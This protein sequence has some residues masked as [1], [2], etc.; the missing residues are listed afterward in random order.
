MKPQVGGKPTP[1][2][3]LVILDRRRRVADAYIRGIP[4]YQIARLESVHESQISRD[5][6]AIR[7]EWLASAVRD[8]DARKAEELAKLDK[9]E[10]TY[11]AAWI[12]SCEDKE[13]REAKSVDSDKPRK[14]ASKREEGRD[15][16]PAF[17]QGV[18]RC[19]SQRC[20]ILDLI[21]KVGSK[22][23]PFE[24]KLQHEGKLEHEHTASERLA[25]Y[26]DVVNRCLS[27]EIRPDGIAEPVDPAETPHEAGGIPPA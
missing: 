2:D 15:G 13:V 5:L 17:L 27:G 7:K 8:F 26:L 4:Q 6:Q 9:L 20:T 11:W 16:N 10:E 12:R 18:E 24:G 19:I 14:E 3:Q 23:K 1:A 25:S 21:P 22:E